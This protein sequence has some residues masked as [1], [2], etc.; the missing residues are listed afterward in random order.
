MENEKVWLVKRQ[1]RKHERCCICCEKIF[2]VA[3]DAKSDYGNFHNVIC[4]SCRKDF[5]AEWEVKENGR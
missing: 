4:D 1:P 2:D 3:Y 5:Y